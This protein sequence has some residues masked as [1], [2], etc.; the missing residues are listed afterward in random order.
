[1]CSNLRWCSDGL[2]FTCWNGEVGRIAFIIDAFEREIIAWSAVGGARIGGSE[3]RDLMLEAVDAQAW[4]RSRQNHRTDGSSLDR[5]APRPSARRRNR[6]TLPAEGLVTGPAEAS[7][8]PP[9][10][11]ISYKPHEHAM[12]GRTRM[13]AAMTAGL[14]G[15]GARPERIMVDA[16][17][18]KAHRTA[19][20]LLKKGLFP[21]VSGVPRAG[22]TPSSTPSATRRENGSSYC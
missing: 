19:A 20:S 18:L 1:M 13:H 8:V 11:A 17:H 9:D 7:P 5:R 16:T 6:A 14:A 15:D 12:R 10:P 22:R 21:A 4:A 3:V 2:E